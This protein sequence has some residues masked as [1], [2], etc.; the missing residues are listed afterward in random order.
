MSYIM[1]VKEISKK[2]GK[3]QVLDSVSINVSK[4]EC[5]GIIGVNGCGKSTLLSI[6]SGSM[7]A[8]KGKVFINGIDT[9]KNPGF[10]MGL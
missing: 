2:Y 8:D 5:V 4:G 6:L 7:K 9:G 3:K 1:E 10:L